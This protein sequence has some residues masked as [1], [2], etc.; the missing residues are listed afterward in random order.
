MARIDLAHEH[1]VYVTRHPSGYIYAGKGKTDSV[2]QGKCKGSGI[3]LNEMFLKEGF[4]FDTWHTVI[5]KTFN[6]AVSA[7]EYERILISMLRSNPKSL[8]LAEGG[9]GGCGMAGK[10][11]RGET[12]LRI[13]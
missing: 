6:D 5:V 2:N 7:Y 1:C 8:N 4:E 13:S 12:Q 9:I 11:Q 10:S 3:R